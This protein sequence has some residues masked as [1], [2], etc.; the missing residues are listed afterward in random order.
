MQ[1]DISRKEQFY[2]VMQELYCFHEVFLTLWKTGAPEFTYDNTIPTACVDFGDN[3][4]VRFLFNTDYWDSLDDYS[5]AFTISHECLHIILNHGERMKH[6]DMTLANIALDL[7]VNHMLINQFE[8]E[9]EKIYNE[10][11]LCW[12]DTVFP[13]QDIPDNLNFEQYY[14]LLLKNNQ[15]D[16]SKVLVDHHV[17]ENSSDIEDLLEDLLTGEV[18]DDLREKLNVDSGFLVDGNGDGSFSHGSLSHSPPKEALKKP[19]E[20]IS[21]VWDSILKDIEE[22]TKYTT[23][24][25]FKFKERRLEFLGKD[26]LIPNAYEEE[27]IHKTTPEIHLYLDSSG[28]CCNLIDDFLALSQTIDPKKYRVK[29]FSMTTKIYPLVARTGGYGYRMYYDGGTDFSSIE[30]HIQQQLRDEIIPKYPVVMFFTDGEDGHTGQVQVEHPQLWYWFLSGR[31]I[32][33]H[34]PEKCANVYRITDLI[35]QM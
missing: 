26:F 13:N 8:F 12:V 14:M 6:C 4:D 5:R 30:R 27:I 33:C 32:K 10:Q 3:K 1:A 17:K 28:S 9:R 16:K 7:A 11:N 29:L 18:F 22:T 21:R 34:I 31:G 15:I 2:K 35:N 23:Q 25:H 24:T 20:R 19:P